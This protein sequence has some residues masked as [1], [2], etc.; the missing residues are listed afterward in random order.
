MEL[1][2]RAQLLSPFHTH[3][4][5]STS[6]DLEPWDLPLLAHKS[7][8][9]LLEALAGSKM[10]SLFRLLLNSR[11]GGVWPYHCDV[12]AEMVLS[13]SF[14]TGGGLVTL[15]AMHTGPLVSPYRSPSF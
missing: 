1:A 14:W 12:F 9:T 2:V 8:S 7:R 11:Q 10:L 15:Q 5:Q 6:Q 4:F 3:D 13:L